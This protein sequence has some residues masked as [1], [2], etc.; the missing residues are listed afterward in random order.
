MG[1]DSLLLNSQFYLYRMPAVKRSSRIRERNRSGIQNSDLVSKVQS[2]SSSVLTIQQQ[3]SEVTSCL[4]N[5]NNLV[6][7]LPLQGSNS[8]Q[9][10]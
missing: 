2:L 4:A 6:N 7:V 3:L 8:L 1:F 10:M 9:N 5:A